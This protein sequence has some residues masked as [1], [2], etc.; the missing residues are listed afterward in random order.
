MDR[1]KE[2]QIDYG[3]DDNNDQLIKAKKKKLI[4]EMVHQQCY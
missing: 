1:K 3:F 2:K 4:D